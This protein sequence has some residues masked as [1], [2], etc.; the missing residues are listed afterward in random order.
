MTGFQPSNPFIHNCYISDNI[1][2]GD[3]TNPIARYTSP[4][5]RSPIPKGLKARNVTAQ[6][7]AST[8]SGGLGQR[9]NIPKPCKGRNNTNPADNTNP[10][11]RYASPRSRPPIPKGLKARNV[12]AQVGAST[13]SGGLGQRPNIPKPC[14]GRNNTN[15]G[16]LSK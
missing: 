5:S 12:T 6:V 3:N 9:P 10:I 8:A 13:A 2:P 16:I 11:A 14:K 1:N 7:G 15:P 4:R